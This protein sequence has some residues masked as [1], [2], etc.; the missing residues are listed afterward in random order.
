[1][2]IDPVMKTTFNLGL[3][4][5]INLGEHN[6]YTNIHQKTNKHVYIHTHIYI[7]AYIH[8]YNTYKQLSSI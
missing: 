7:H 2:I 1:M 5:L 6:T 4:S 8:T 3:V